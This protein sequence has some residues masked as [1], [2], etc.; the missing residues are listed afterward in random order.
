MGSLLATCNLNTTWTYTPCE[1]PGKKQPSLLYTLHTFDIYV[2][3]E[4]IHYPHE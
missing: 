3:S 4:C 1:E 2:Y